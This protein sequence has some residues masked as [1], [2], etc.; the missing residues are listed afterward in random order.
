MKKFIDENVYSIGRMKSG[1][2]Y[3]ELI[4]DV[5]WEGFPDYA[6]EFIKQFSG[7]I[8]NRND[9]VDTRVWGVIIK[10]QSLRLVYEDFPV[11]IS[12]ESQSEGGDRFIEELR[13]ILIS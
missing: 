2:L 12:L 1:K 6:E 4:S 11:M 10:G 8:I 5:G 9:S 3:V 7:S 13:E